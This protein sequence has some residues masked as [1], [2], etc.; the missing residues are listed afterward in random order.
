MTTFTEYLHYPFFLRA[1]LVGG[2]ISLVLSWMSGYVVLRKEVL[3]T[4]S[5]SNIGFLGVALAIL[6]Q[7]PVTPILIASCVIAAYLISVLQSKKIF[8]NDSLLEIF[9]Q[10]GLAL[11]VIVIALFPGYRI[12]IEQFLF[13]DIL[14]ISSVDVYITS[15]LALASAVTIFL[16]H[17][18]FLQISLSD[19]LS[20]SHLKN[21]RLW[22]AL[23]ILLLALMIALAMKIV[24]VLLVA[25]FTTITSNTA[26]LFAKNIR[27][28]FIYSSLIGLI[29][30]ILGLFASA[31]LNL[32]SGPAIVLAMVI[33][34]LLAIIKNALSQRQDSSA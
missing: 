18:K 21:K 24:G 26:K 19:L 23:L 7:L 2:T 27:Q 29:A 28:T 12:N 32:P 31:S 4:H 34:W 3:F 10:S 11:A 5:L 30:T 15:A 6:L 14:G 25:A 33:F 16:F 17:K 20:H 9:S 1:L 8:N 22:H 13:G